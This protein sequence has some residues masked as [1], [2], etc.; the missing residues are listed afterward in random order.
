MLWIGLHLPLLSLE[1]FLATLPAQHAGQP[2]ALVEAHQVVHA[3]ARAQALGVKPGLKRATALALAP[4]LLLGQADALRDAQALTGIA[5]AALAFSPAVCLSAPQ[6]V[7]VEVEASLRYF[8]GREA[9]LQRLR[10]A[11]QPLGHQVHCVSTPTAQGSAL[12]ARVHDGLHC[13]D[14]AALQRALDAAP[15][16]LLGPGHEH[17]DALQGMG[18]NTLGDLRSLPRAGLARRFGESLLHEFDAALGHRP[19]PRVAVELPARFHSELELFARADTTEQVMHGSQVL[20]SRL[21]AWLSAQHAFVRRFSLQMKHE[22]RWRRDAQTPQHTTLELA[23]AEPSR[24][25]KHLAALLRERLSQLQLAAPTLELALRASDIARKPPPNAEL[26]PTPRSEQ[27]GLTRLLERL[28]ARLGRERV[29]RVLPVQDH[30]P[31]R[32]S[33]VC[34]ARSEGAAQSGP[35]VPRLRSTELPL[36]AGASRPVWLLPQALPLGERQSQP[37]LDGQP[38]QLLAGPER[39][40]AGWWDGDGIERDYFIAQTAEG[41]LVWLYRARLPFSDQSEGEGWFLQ[42]RYG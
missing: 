41:A 17:W 15:V 7:L 11:L 24:D 28:Q 6:G 35:A 29:Q 10:D 36:Q 22:P 38:L 34:A 2:V 32:G 1:S 18:L 37:L 40:E 27:E 9:L 25:A 3:C 21:V 13:A 30:R 12:L 20:L 5:H 16:W 19:D 42:G 8:G 26:F 31:E 14:A 33:L 39:I 23:L 4:Q